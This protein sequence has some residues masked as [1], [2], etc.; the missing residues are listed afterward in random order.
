MS[1]IDPLF[2]LTDFRCQEL[3]DRD[4]T[5]R[6][7]AFPCPAGNPEEAHS[8]IQHFHDE[9]VKPQIVDSLAKED[10]LIWVEYLI[11]VR[12]QLWAFRAEAGAWAGCG[13]DEEGANGRGRSCCGGGDVKGELSVDDVW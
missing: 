5:V 2:F 8:S 13:R 11:G 7:P 1:P 9:R 3:C 10:V 6:Y 12:M 4:Q